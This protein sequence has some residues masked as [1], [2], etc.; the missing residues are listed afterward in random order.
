M[1][2]VIG[3]RHSDPNSKPEQT[4]LSTFLIVRIPLGKKYA[5]NYSPSRYG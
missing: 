1:D 3:N 5:S 2:I 4:R